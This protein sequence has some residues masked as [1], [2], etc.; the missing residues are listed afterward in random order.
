MPGF[1]SKGKYIG[2]N[3]LVFMSAGGKSWKYELESIK[4]VKRAL[5]LHKL[6]DMNAYFSFVFRTIRIELKNVLSRLK[7]NS[8]VYLWRSIKW[9]RRG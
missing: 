7:L 8:V 4:E 1:R 9:N 2:G 3:A 5:Q 6:W